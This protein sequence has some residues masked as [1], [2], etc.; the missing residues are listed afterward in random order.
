MNALISGLFSRDQFIIF[1]TASALVAT[2]RRKA[3]DLPS[4]IGLNIGVM[5][6]KSLKFL[7]L[8]KKNFLV[9]FSL[10]SKP[11]EMH[12]VSTKADF[13]IPPCLGRS[14]ITRNH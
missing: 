13:S 6:Q 7:K 11:V 12:S 1:Y 14:A 10:S 8:K 5:D 4:A 3:R 9:F 2:L